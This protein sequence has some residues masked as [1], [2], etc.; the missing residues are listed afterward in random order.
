MNYNGEVLYQKLMEYYSLRTKPVAYKYFANAE[1]IENDTNFKQV[2]GAAMPC[3]LVGKAAYKGF[4]QYIKPTQMAPYCAG[5]NGMCE[6]TEEWME[7][8]SED[9]VDRFVADKEG[10]K[11]H[12]QALTGSKEIY[13]AFA[14]APLQSNAIEDPDGVAIYVTPEQLFYM[15]LHLQH[16]NY[17]K[18]DFRFV[19]ESTCSDGM[20]YTRETGK[21]G[22]A[23]GGVGERE[24]GGLPH[25][26]LIVT[27][28]IAQI[29]K[30]LDS[31]KTLR[32]DSRFDRSHPVPPLCLGID[33]AMLGNHFDFIEKK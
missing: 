12:H 28:T 29:E 26:E 22:V 15:L 31:A 9:F 21:V 27:M 4:C 33:M 18:M 11:K 5:V 6:R 25:T 3:V 2:E 24:F 20:V 13:Q 16:K 7:I 1:I 8:E 32:Y 19:G 14:A 17:E 30:M 10:A 23:I